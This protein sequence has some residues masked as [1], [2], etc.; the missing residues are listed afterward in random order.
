MICAA[1]LN[2]KRFREGSERVTFMVCVGT[3]QIMILLFHEPFVVDPYHLDHRKTCA[4]LNSAFQKALE[5]VTFMF[6]VGMVWETL[7]YCFSSQVLASLPVRQQAWENSDQ[8]YMLHFIDAS[9]ILSVTDRPGFQEKQPMQSGC[10]FSQIWATEKI[11][12]CELLLS[13]RILV[14]EQWRP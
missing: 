6:R 9:L 14:S 4:L 2:M 10:F 1:Q 3:V 5:R 8:K 7:E 13:G 11:N 12:K